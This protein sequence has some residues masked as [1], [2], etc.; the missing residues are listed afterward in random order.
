MTACRP[1]TWST[2]QLSF[3]ANPV[4]GRGHTVLAGRHVGGDDAIVGEFV[5]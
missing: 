1:S 4:I 5:R 2:G 3:G